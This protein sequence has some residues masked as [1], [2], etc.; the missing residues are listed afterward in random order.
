[1]F[2]SITLYSLVSFI[3]VAVGYFM[4]EANILNMMY[5]GDFTRISFMIMGLFLWQHWRLGVN[6]WQYNK[7]YPITNKELNIGFEMSDNV[8]TLGMIGTVLGFIHMTAS[9]VGVDF[10]DIANIQELFVL[11]TSGMSTALYTTLAGLIAH[12]LIRAS[13]FAVEMHL[14]GFD[15]EAA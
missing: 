15:E 10:S 14:K 2:N 9:F 6:I 4:F 7:G 13:Y 3:L 8:M 12:I 1:M 5:E 11:A